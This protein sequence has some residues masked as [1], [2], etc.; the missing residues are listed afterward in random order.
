MLMTFDQLS[1]YLS[2]PK[3]TLYKLSC[4]RLLPKVKIKG[5]VRFDQ[6]QIDE[7]IKEHSVPALEQ[8]QTHTP[9]PKGSNN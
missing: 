9:L 2:I 8:A 1:E 3:S 5:N 7:W 6:A 4:Q